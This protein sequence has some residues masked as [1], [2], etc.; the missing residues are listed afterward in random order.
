MR[1]GDWCDCAAQIRGG[2]TYFYYTGSYSFKKWRGEINKVIA[3]S[4]SRPETLAWVLQPA[5]L[6][7]RGTSTPSAEYSV[8]L[9]R[10]VLTETPSKRA[11]ALRFP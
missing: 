7:Q 5:R 4:C 8:I 3:Y 11:E 10:R 9:F 1:S 6:S 2:D